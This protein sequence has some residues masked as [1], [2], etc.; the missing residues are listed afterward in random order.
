MLQ[1]HLI[2]IGR[3]LFDHHRPMCRCIAMQKKLAVLCPF[4]L[5]FLFCCM[6]EATRIQYF[7]LF[8]YNKCIVAKTASQ[9]V[10]TIMTLGCISDTGMATFIPPVNLHF[11]HCRLIICFFNEC[12]QLLAAKYPAWYY[13]HSGNFLRLLY[14]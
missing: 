2:M 11:L 14:I 3:V 5:T 12:Y 6:A 8:V 7:C 1:S 10:W 13:S 9:A 4:F